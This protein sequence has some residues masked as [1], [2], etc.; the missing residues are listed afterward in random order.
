MPV[1]NE[2]STGY[3]PSAS[4]PIPTMPASFY[5]GK[6]PISAL[7]SG[8]AATATATGS[9]SADVQDNHA[10]AASGVSKT[11][12]TATK[13][14]STAAAVETSTDSDKGSW[15]SWGSWGQG[16]DAQVTP[17]ADWEKRSAK[18]RN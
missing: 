8:S 11:T 13:S 14:S 9:S 7:L 16:A 18:F 2:L 17:A 4:I 12:S 6:Q 10:A 1:D 3:D 15:G 5:P